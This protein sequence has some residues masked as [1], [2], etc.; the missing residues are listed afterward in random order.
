MFINLVFD[1]TWSTS[2]AILNIC[3]VHIVAQHSSELIDFNV[4]I[5]YT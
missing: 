3:N 5:K 4:Y 2:F 1:V